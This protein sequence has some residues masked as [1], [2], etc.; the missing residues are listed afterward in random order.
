MDEKVTE[1]VRTFPI[2]TSARRHVKSFLDLAGNYRKFVRSY[3]KLIGP[4]Q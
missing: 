2:P 3:A 4:L 1:S